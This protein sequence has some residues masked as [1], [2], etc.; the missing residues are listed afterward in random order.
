MVAELLARRAAGRGPPRR[1]RRRDRVNWQLFGEAFVTLFVIIDPPGTVPIFLGPHLDHGHPQAPRR[2]ARQAVLVA[3]GVIVAFAV[4]GQTILD[5]LGI[6]LPALQAAGGLLL[7]LVALELLTDNAKE[8]EAQESV[9]IA[10]VPLGTP[11]LAGPG[12]HRRDHAVRP[13]RRRRG[14]PRVGRRRHRRGARGAVP[15]APLRG[16]DPPGAARRRGHPGD[17][18]RRACCCPRSRCSSWPTRSGPSSRPADA[19]GRR[20]PGRAAGAPRSGEA[21]PA[22]RLLLVRALRERGHE[23]ADAAPGPPQ[24]A[25]RR[26][27]RGRRERRPSRR[28]A[29]RGTC[30]RPRR[31]ASR[32]P[33]RPA[34]SSPPGPGVMSSSSGWIGGASTTAT[35]SRAGS[36]RRSPGRTS[37]R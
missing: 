8:P 23:R 26:G 15:R 19:A 12:R 4:F 6:S 22:Q 9:N 30:P 13:A 37:A 34:S 31:A 3:F 33:A 11:L 14:R 28:A 27:H 2:A 17:P 36:L 10:L 1:R 16:P 5:Y 18:D 25:Q 35:A 21:E 7:L 24:R 20:R 32:R 29:G